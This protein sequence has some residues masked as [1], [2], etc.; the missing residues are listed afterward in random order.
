MSG[1]RLGIKLWSAWGE[2]WPDADN[3]ISLSEEQRQI[4]KIQSGQRH[5]TFHA[6]ACAFSALGF[7]RWNQTRSYNAEQVGVITTGGPVQ[8]EVAWQFLARGLSLGH[9]AVNPLAFP[10][11][12]VS[13]VPTSLAASVQAKAFAFAV[14][15]DVH[16]FFSAL[17]RAKTMLDAGYCDA[18]LIVAALEANPTIQ[19]VARA[20]GLNRPVGDAAV[21]GVVEYDDAP[22]PGSWEI[23]EISAPQRIETKGATSMRSGSDVCYAFDG[24]ELK[25]SSIP[26]ALANVN[27]LTASGGVACLEAMA[28]SQK[29]ST[30]NARSHGFNLVFEG[31][32]LVSILRLDAPR[33][34]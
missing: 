18:V 17:R 7:K 3:V 27:T 14:G 31:E 11:T 4:V 9:D 2:I 8:L 30:L 20:A 19:N 22:E 5:A 12:I 28:H 32:G 29:Q 23:S 10:N 6:G 16:A 15:Y 34:S 21:C 24:W 33:D 25:S 1:V 26:S 13:G